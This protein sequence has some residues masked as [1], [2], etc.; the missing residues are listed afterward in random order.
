MNPQWFAA[1]SCAP[2]KS[3]VS[4]P[5]QQLCHRAVKNLN[6]LGTITL[7]NPLLAHKAGADNRIFTYTREPAP[8]QRGDRK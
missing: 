3:V 4:M 7:D 1:H 2:V 8:N 5:Q 6:L